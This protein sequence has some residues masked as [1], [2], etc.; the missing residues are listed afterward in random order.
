MAS[1]NT[2]VPHAATLKT[3]LAKVGRKGRRP[4]EGTLAI[5]AAKSAEH[6]AA[7]EAYRKA[8]AEARQLARERARQAAQ[9]KAEA[10]AVAAICGE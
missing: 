2:I 7:V 8:D 10:K 3:L 6:A 1:E 5:V 9:A 4:S